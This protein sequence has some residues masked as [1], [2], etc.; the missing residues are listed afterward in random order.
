ML[1]IGKVRGWDL[2]DLHIIARRLSVA[3]VTAGSPS[4]FGLA[5]LQPLLCHGDA[6]G[7]REARE[8]RDAHPMGC[9]IQ[10]V[11]K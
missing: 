7:E 10:L 1:L 6:V 11:Q 8:R 5:H 9:E 4:G 3:S 2:G